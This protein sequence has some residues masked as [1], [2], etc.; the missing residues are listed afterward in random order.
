MTPVSEASPQTIDQ[1]FRRPNKFLG[2]KNIR[3]PKQIRRPNFLLFTGYR[4]V[5]KQLRL[6]FFERRSDAAQGQDHGE[7]GAKAN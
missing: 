3:R 6:G 7:L 4:K 1:Q 5:P 2:L